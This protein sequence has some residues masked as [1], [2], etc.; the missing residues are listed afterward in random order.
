MIELRC[1]YDKR[2]CITINYHE[3]DKEVEIFIKEVRQDL[4]T[5]YLSIEDAKILHNYLGDIINDK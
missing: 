4:R 1:N 2:D 3:Q 5:V